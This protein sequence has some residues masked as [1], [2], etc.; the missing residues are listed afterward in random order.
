M[1]DTAMGPEEIAQPPR[2]DLAGLERL[3][4][5]WQITGGAD[6]TATYEWLEGGYFV[7]QHVELE[8]HGERIKGIEVI[9]RERAFD[10]DPGEEITSRFYDNQGNTLDYTYE[11]DGDIL[12]IWGGERGSPAYFKGE[13]SANGDTIDGAWVYPGGGRYDSTMTRIPG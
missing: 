10:A 1:T 3:I 8:Q 9:G 7:I 6:G 11:V 4:G 5:R 12:T 13:F 2:P